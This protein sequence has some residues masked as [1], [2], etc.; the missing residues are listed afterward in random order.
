MENHDHV[1]RA[2]KM[3]CTDD[4]FEDQRVKDTHPA[5]RVTIYVSPKKTVKV[6]RRSRIRRRENQEF[7]VTIGTP[8]WHERQRIKQFIKVGEPFPVKRPQLQYDPPKKR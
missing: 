8:N 2:L 7:I 5:H 6:T 1:A 4:E 3:F